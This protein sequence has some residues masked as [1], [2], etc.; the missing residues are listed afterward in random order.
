M[1]GAKNCLF[2]ALLDISSQPE[3]ADTDILAERDTDIFS[4]Q[5]ETPNNAKTACWI[6]LVQS[7]PRDGNRIFVNPDNFVNKAEKANR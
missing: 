1:G 6:L 5:R 2:S 3:A 4:G 7:E